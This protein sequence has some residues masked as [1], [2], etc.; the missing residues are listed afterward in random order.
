MTSLPTTKLQR[1]RPRKKDVPDSLKRIVSL[2]AI[3]VAGDEIP[4][5]QEVV[6]ARIANLSHALMSTE[7]RQQTRTLDDTD[8]LSSTDKFLAK[9]AQ[10]LVKRADE[11]QSYVSHLSAR[12]L[13]S[14]K[15]SPDATANFIGML[16][17]MMFDLGWEH[18]WVGGLIHYREELRKTA[19]SL[20]V[21][22]DRRHGLKNKLG[23]HPRGPSKPS[24]ERREWIRDQWVELCVKGKKEKWQYIVAKKLATEWNPT[25]GKPGV[26]VHEWNQDEQVRNGYRAT[27]S[28]EFKELLE[29]PN[30]YGVPEALLNVGFI[31]A[32]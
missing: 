14:A 16:A 15:D 5:A 13:E 28:D 26:T 18:G 8:K 9:K 3:A 31:L 12:I 11:W 1:V 27:V 20:V 10:Q 30:D 25:H 19:P 4:S 22:L 32:P 7:F 24:R 17:L 6:C 29:H 23:G 21:D 2:P